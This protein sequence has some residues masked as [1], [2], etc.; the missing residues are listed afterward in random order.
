MTRALGH[1]KAKITRTFLKSTDRRDIIRSFIA[2]Y[3]DAEGNV[4]SKSH[5]ITIG[6]TNLSILKLVQKALMV[7]GGIRSKIYLKSKIGES[8]SLNGFQ[9]RLRKNY[10][11]LFIRAPSK[12][13]LRWIQTVGLRLRH[14]KKH[15][16]AIALKLLLKRESGPARS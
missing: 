10:W 4:D 11:C 6:S 3:F 5:S 15:R 13:M 1:S 9:F 8:R 7:D 2:G 16:E 12:S 14:P